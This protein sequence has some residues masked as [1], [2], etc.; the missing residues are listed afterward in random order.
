MIKKILTWISLIIIVLIIG[1][2]SIWSERIY[3]CNISYPVETRPKIYDIS[4]PCK[5]W[6]IVDKILGHPD[7]KFNAFY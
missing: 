2:L 3:A 5:V 6:A 1:A 7:R 4:S